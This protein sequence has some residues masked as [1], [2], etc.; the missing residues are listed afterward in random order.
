MGREEELITQKS[1]NNSDEK[2]KDPPM[3]L[4]T[5]DKYRDY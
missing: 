4:K 3:M 2:T 1:T 5:V